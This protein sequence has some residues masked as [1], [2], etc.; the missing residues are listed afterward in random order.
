MAGPAA[1]I[2]LRSKVS[3]H[4]ARIRLTTAHVAN[5]KNARRIGSWRLANT[6]T[7]TT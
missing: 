7:S 3:R 2:A 6:P 5:C 1:M 4:N